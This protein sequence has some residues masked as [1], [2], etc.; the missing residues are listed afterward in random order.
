MSST[1]NCENLPTLLRC[2][3]SYIS[4]LHQTDT[5]L[6]LASGQWLGDLTTTGTLPPTFPTHPVISDG[7][8]AAFLADKQFPSPGWVLLQIRTIPI[9]KNTTCACTPTTKSTSNAYMALPEV[10]GHVNTCNLRNLWRDMARKL[11]GH[12]GEVAEVIPGDWL[13]EFLSLALRVYGEEV[14]IVTTDDITTVEMDDV[15]T[16]PIPNLVPLHC[17]LISAESVSLIYSYKPH[18]IASMLGFSPALLGDS[19]TKT[20]FLLHQILEIFQSFHSIGLAIGDSVSLHDLKIDNTF[21]ILYD[22]NLPHPFTPVYPASL[23]SS[24]LAPSLSLSTPL[25]MATMLWTRRELSTLQYLLFLNHLAGRRFGQPNNHPVVPWVTD[26]TSKEGGH[27]DLSRSKF[28]LNK[29]DQ[30]LDMTYETGQHHVTDVLSEITYYTYKSR[31]TDKAVLCRY[32]RPAWVP[33]EYPASMARMMSWSPD[34]AI[35][36]FYT[37]P[38]IFTSLHPDLPDLAL[39]SWAESGEEFCSW[40]LERLEGDMV[41]THIHTWIDLTF[42]YKLSGSAAVRSKNVC[43]DIA[44]SH[45]DL[46]GHGV[47]QLFSVPHPVRGHVG[48]RDMPVG[49]EDGVDTVG[50]DEDSDEGEEDWTITNGTGDAIIDE[51]KISFPSDFNASS[52]LTELETLN[53]FLSKSGSASTSP[54]SAASSSCSTVSKP[55]V[56]DMQVL[57]CLVVELFLPRKTVTQGPHCSLLQRYEAATKHLVSL[58]PCVKTMATQLLLPD[59]KFGMTPGD[60]Y[61]AVSVFGLPLPSPQQLLNPLMSPVPFPSF[62]PT[63]LHTLSKCRDLQSQLS[64]LSITHPTQ[65]EEHIS[66]VSEFC[67]LLVARSLSPMLPLLSHDCLELVIPL[68]TSLLQSPHT[69]VF[70]SWLLL[71]KIS[72]TLGADKTKESFLDPVTSLYLNGSPTAKHAKLYHR[73]FL[74]TLIV[75]FKLKIFLENFTNYLVEA[76]GGYKDLEW[77]TGRQG[78]DQSIRSDKRE[79]VGDSVASQVSESV[80]GEKG[81]VEC[82]TFSEGEVFAF[83]SLDEQLAAGK[84]G[85]ATFPPEVLE[86]VAQNLGS[87]KYGSEESL[88]E[89]LD[90]AR[91]TSVV[92]NEAEKRD[93]EGNI[94]TV[95]GESVLWL[96]HRLA[97]CWPAGSSPETCC[98]C[99]GCAT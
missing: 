10:L 4:P 69:A 68:V 79:E 67:V 6:L 75:R 19:Q 72:S 63:L 62:F 17:I 52:E 53:Y 78:L 65:M 9:P 70:S 71:D 94:S 55:K 73:S 83:D 26:F 99:W 8:V 7:E 5:S 43:L 74:M 61:P 54:A 77:D 37:D 28:R 59:Q 3:P 41:S 24:P 87:T 23:S 90:I 97:P 25:S 33:A 81:Q 22:Y 47:V 16:P 14:V 98:A 86:A 40:H 13:Q 57:G 32:V 18:S 39:P 46:R 85:A 42:G 95:A 58:P 12:S 21:H 29:G 88:T 50:A 34:E 27:R 36:E 2:P 80:V 44:D 92:D 20:L 89:V 76:V 82:E 93:N 15:E 64:L 66:T 84:F 48:A 51:K 91:F 1:E 11:G 31:V 30:A 35:P 56:V 96:A 49:R 60:R 38:H 45:V